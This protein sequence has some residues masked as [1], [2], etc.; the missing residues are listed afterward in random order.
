MGVEVTVKKEGEGP[1]PQKGQAVTSHVTGYV[2]ESG[3]KFW[4]TKD[5]GQDV[6]TFKIGL[7]QVIKGWD[8]GYKTLKKGSVADLV[9]TSDYAYGDRGFPA[10]KIPGKAT[11]RFEVEVISIV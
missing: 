9:C 1:T 7:G 5:P 2:V 8:E 3:Y 6:F 4:S 11:L 10:W